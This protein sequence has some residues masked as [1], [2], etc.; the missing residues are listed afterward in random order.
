VREEGRVYV[1]LV[2]DQ[3]ETSTDQDFDQ[4]SAQGSAQYVDQG[5]GEPERDP[6][7]RDELVEELRDR[8]RYLEEESRRKDH[9]LAAALERIP[10]IEAPRETRA[11]SETPSDGEAGTGTPAGDTGQP[12]R[13]WWRKFF[14]F[15]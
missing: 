13:S 9:L 6:D 1:I 5:Q 4:G 3:G 12:R 2:G 11:S 8:V 14:G 10:A 15:E 7:Y